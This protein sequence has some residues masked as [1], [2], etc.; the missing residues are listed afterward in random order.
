VKNARFE[1]KTELAESEIH[2]GERAVHRE[3]DSP[4]ALVIVTASKA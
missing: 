1:R 2:T 3:G 4:F